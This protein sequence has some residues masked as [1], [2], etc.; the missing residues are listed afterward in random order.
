MLCALCVAVCLLGVPDS[1]AAGA[2]RMPD[3]LVRVSSQVFRLAEE[4]GRARQRYESGVWAAKEQTAGVRGVA[5][6]LRQQRIVS[7]ALREDAGAAARAQYRTGG[8]TAADAPT[9]AS[10]DPMELLGRRSSA[11]RRRELLAASLGETDRR[12]RELAAREQSAAASWPAA[13]EDLARLRAERRVADRRL[14]A[15]RGELDAMARAAIAGGRCEPLDRERFTTAAGAYGP[16]AV[17]TA[18]AAEEADWARPV[19]SYELSAGYGDSG[20]SWARG[21]T[22]QDFAVPTG[23]PVRS[24]GAG[25]VVSAGCGGPFGIS[26][27]IR[28]ADGWYSQYAHL[29]ASFVAP[30]E[31][32]LPGQWIG[33]SGTTGNSTGPHLH[34]E[35][36]TKPGYGSAVDPVAWLRVRGVRL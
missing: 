22:G 29:S 12:S 4:A 23:T 21:H 18:G 28:H 31:P 36:R 26:L 7:S 24:V 11:E 2:G 32:V 14:A 30:G 15:A 13:E 9:A 25:T 6:Q 16:A 1:S 10:D 34:F 33:L 20:A 17:D 27:V 8:F 3:R 35:I 19:L 5:R